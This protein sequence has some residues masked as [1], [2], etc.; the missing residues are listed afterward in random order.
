M[1]K[2]SNLSISKKMGLLSGISL[3][4]LLFIGAASFWMITQLS[5]ALN[6]LSSVQIVAMHDA[7]QADMM[8]DGLRAVVF[9]SII[10]AQ[11]DNETEKHESVEEL[12]EFTASFRESLES[13]EKLPMDGETKESVKQVFPALEDYI[14]KSEEI[15]AIAL[16]GQPD[17]AL[18][19][20]PKFQ[21]Q[22]KI[23]EDRMEKLGNL[24]E[25]NSQKSQEKSEK[26]ATFAKTSLIVISVLSFG[27]ALSLSIFLASSVI[28]RLKMLAELVE[29]LSAKNIEEKIDCLA[30]DEI[31]VLTRAFR[32]AYQ[33]L[34]RVAE[35]AEELSRGK[36]DVALAARSEDDILSRNFMVV[37]KTLQ[38]L[39]DETSTLTEAA[40]SGNLSSRGRSDRFQ[41]GYRELIENINGTL[42]SITTPINEASVALEKIADRD[43][44]VQMTG[45]YPGD[46]AKIK[47][48]VNLAADNLKQGFEKVACSADQVASAAEQINQGSQ[49]LAQSASE[50]ASSLEE[51][52]GSIHEISAK[53][54]QN[55]ASTGEARTL[56]T[57]ALKIA[58]NGLSNM[59]RLSNAFERI[60]QSSDS[61]AKIVKT[62][63]E[64][65]FQTNLLALNAA[66]EAARAGDA[67]KGFAVVAE[68]VRNLAMRSAEAA[69]S[70]ATMIDE[71]VANTSEGVELNNEV[72][73]NLDAINL[74]IGKVST[75]VTEIA[76][77]TAQQSQGIEQINSAIEQMNFV[78]QQIAANSEE[79]A[80]SAEEL[81]S[82]SLE[83]LSLINTY[84][85]DA[86][87]TGAGRPS[88]NRTRGKFAPPAPLFASNN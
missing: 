61:T 38:N 14:K 3:V 22:F 86:A 18:K 77:A 53:T 75:V 34:E 32:D 69:R 43:L 13:L 30:E 70:S 35:A 27:L 50:Q 40:Q 41:G 52:S 49:L 23:L 64:I 55:A 24:I 20:I 87:G 57:D 5:N 42:N 39:V 15:S 58:E 33:Y 48:S 66:V 84:R 68:E 37:T 81:S 56:S 7:M 54:R 21:E 16:S 73:K 74:Q 19:E 82:Q 11:T 83:M 60:K 36:F 31:G 78:T 44:T 8:H 62:I 65:A 2:L 80:S 79:S 25:Q 29:R 9:R 10:A 59:R 88:Q 6:D 72:F 71:A 1:L 76:D 45:D 63:E 28:G 4:A 46:F 12:K 26:Q 51:V 67:G 85:L 47:V 17:K